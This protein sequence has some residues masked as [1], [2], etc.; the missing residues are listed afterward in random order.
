MMFDDNGFT[1]NDFN[2]DYS[3]EI[4]RFGEIETSPNHNL[5]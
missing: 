3:D 5:I 1:N 4:L 2:E